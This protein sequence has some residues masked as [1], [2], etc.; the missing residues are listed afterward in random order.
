MSNF[1]SECFREVDPFAPCEHQ[2]GGKSKDDFSFQKS[3]DPFSVGPSKGGFGLQADQALFLAPL[4]GLLLD[5]VF[6]SWS[7]PLVSIVLALLGGALFMFVWRQRTYGFKFNPMYLIKN[8][9][10]YLIPPL[11]S[12]GST[13]KPKTYGVWVGGLAVSVLLQGAIFS[14]GNGAFLENRVRTYINDR[15]PVGL[16]VD[17]PAF[18]FIPLGGQVTC[19]VGTGVF[20]ITVPARVQ[21][22]PFTNAVDVKVSLN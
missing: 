15:S 2:A 19:E 9:P 20:G 14:P 4:S 12:V 1:C 3:K 11:G 13:S 16:S 22:S 7:N 17:C 21:I 18:A 8:L 5:L 6:P 10:S